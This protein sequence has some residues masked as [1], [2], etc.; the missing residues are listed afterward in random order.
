MLT[1]ERMNLT[2]KTV[3]NFQHSTDFP[4]SMQSNPYV[5]VTDGSPW[6]LHD[7]GVFPSVSGDFALII[8][9]YL[10]VASLS[11]KL[12]YGKYIRFLLCI[13]NH[14]KLNDLKQPIFVT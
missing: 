14:H 9:A 4:E 10:E 13:I 3:G 1:T 8:C 12:I 7:T 5:K 11:L 6:K 2:C